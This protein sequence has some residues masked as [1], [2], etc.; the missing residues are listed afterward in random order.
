MNLP[1]PKTCNLSVM[2]NN[3]LLTD[4]MLWDYA[5]GFLETKDK[6]RVDAYLLQHPEHRERLDA[7]LAEKR[8]F[9]ALPLEKPKAGFADR[10]MAAWAAEQAHAQA[11]KPGKDWM[12]YII[13]AVFGLFIMSALVMAGM[14]QAPAQLP[15]ELPQMPAFD[16][17]AIFS[18]RVLQYGLYFSLALLALKFVEK[19]L[20][21][22][23][24][25]DTLKL[26]G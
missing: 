14:Q 11:T 22:R 17:G 2:E 4:D 20:E 1:Q 25:L 24:V 15:V 7:I 8:A 12:I 19:Y 16:W 5:D 21:Q 6:V 3:F 9:A 18:N 13:S 26:Q 10:V 23:R